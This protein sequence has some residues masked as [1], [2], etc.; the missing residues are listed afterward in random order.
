MSR[1]RLISIRR[2]RRASPAQSSFGDLYLERSDCVFWTLAPPGILLHNFARR[3]FVELDS[4]GYLAWG[5]LDGA[6]TVTEVVM[7]CVARAPARSRPAA[8]R[9]TLQLV[10]TLF[11][12]GF[13]IT[14]QA[15]KPSLCC[16]PS[17]TP[18]AT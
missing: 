13:V 5:Y 11:D 1:N 18:T 10:R 9:K 6:R 14:A 2:H 8:R 12:N 3:R 4:T 17:R 7:R 16:L 15:E